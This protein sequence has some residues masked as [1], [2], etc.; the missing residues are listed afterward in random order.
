MMPTFDWTRYLTLI[1]EASLHA[2]ASLGP[3]VR[4]QQIAEEIAAAAL[5]HEGVKIASADVL[6]AIERAEEELLVD[7]VI[8]LGNKIRAEPEPEPVV[9]QPEPSYDRDRSGHRRPLKR[10]QK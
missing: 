1:E 4:R 9:R 6:R 7:M 5:E 2:T 8:A 3:P 10:R